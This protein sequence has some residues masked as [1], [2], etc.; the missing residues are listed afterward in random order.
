MIAFG[1]HP[2]PLVLCAVAAAAVTFFTYRRSMPRPAPPGLAL[3]LG[4]RFLALLLLLCLLFQPF[5]RVRA[6]EEH[7][8]VLAVLVDDSQSLGMEARSPSPAQVVDS[9]LRHLPEI[10]GDKRLFA[11]SGGARALDGPDSLRFLGERTD[12]SQALDDV[13]E[14]LESEH[15]RGVLLLS[16]GQYNTG[17]SPLY[18]AERYGAPIHTVAVGDT[19]RQRDVQIRRITT[20][21][22]GYVGRDTPVQVGILAHGYENEQVVASLLEGSTLLSTHA[23]TLPG[24]GLDRPVDMTFTPTAE[25]LRQLSV[26]VTELDGEVSYRNNRE[27]FTIR[28]LKNRRRVLV[29]AAAPHPDLA[30]IRGFLLDD[31]DTEV[32]SF[33]QKDPGSFY[34]GSAPDSY[35]DFDLVVLMGFPGRG[36]SPAVVQRVAG[37]AASGAR[38]LFMLT[39]Q[40]DIAQLRSVLGAALPVTPVRVRATFED[41]SFAP[42]S[43]GLQ[44]AILDLPDLATALTRLPPLSSSLTHWESSP[45]ARVLAQASL[46]GVDLDEP[47]LVVRSRAGNRSAALLGSGTWRWMNLPEDL[48]AFSSLWPMLFDNLTQWLTTPEDDRRVR[49]QP[50]MSTF[51]GG[52]TIQFTGQ[53][54]DESLNPVGDASVSLEITTPDGARYPY[55][56][57]ALGGGRYVIDIGT[58]PEGSYAYEAQAMRREATFG[59]DTGVFTVGALTLEFRETSTNASLLRQI[60]HRSGGQ[61]FTPATLDELSSVLAADSSFAPRMESAVRERALWQW[62]V[63]FAIVILLLTTEWILRKRAGMS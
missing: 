46:R 44:H 53:V 1:L 35:S 21:D 45:D 20:N 38:L 16:D 8:A 18:V 41:A 29:L 37:A 34:E 59:R 24:D 7:P 33:V 50:A 48:G 15:L 61:F 43:A 58:L 2:W 26:A 31:A 5:W 42:T 12:L 14:A 47:M 40:T 32:V 36:A 62:P 19:L 57:D 22:I 4:L 23:L 3:L 52:E 6:V 27:T 25:G 51:A 60:A 63:P 55:T 13:R 30:A 9:A 28:I 49:V 54:Y 56:L 39:P 10:A 11:F 17:R